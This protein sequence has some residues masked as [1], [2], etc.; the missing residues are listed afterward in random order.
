MSSRLRLLVTT[1]DLVGRGAERELVNLLR[2]IPRDRF[3]VHLCLWR[4]VFDYA[5]P[6]DVPVA[7]LDKRRWWHVFRARRRLARL[8]D[9]LQPDLVY[10]QL[11]YVSTVTGSALAAAR[12]PPAWI[13]RL[14]GN[15]RVEIRQPVLA[16]TR[17]SLRR[18]DAVVGCSRGAGR[19][20]VEHLRIPPQRVR[21]LPNVVDVDEVLRLAQAPSPVPK[22]PGVFVF[23]S[24][25]RLTP[26]KNHA[27]LLDAFARLN[28]PG[29]ELWILGEGPL[30]TSLQR[31]A[32]RLGI[33]ESVRW[34]G[35]QKNP[36]AVLRAADV[37]VLSSDYEGLP[38]ALIEA[39][40]CGLPAVSTDSPFGPAEL[41]DDGLGRLVPVGDAEALASAMRR[42]LDERARAA[43]TGRAARERIVDLLHPDRIVPQYL[44]LFEQCARSKERG[45]G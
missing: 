36:F 40:L 17:R 11:N 39:M 20:I 41:I 18:A 5:P 23:A 10:S 32:A 15:P 12:R 2:R 24:A 25:G 22:P 8:I 44:S 37:F 29:C 4:A 19:A 30:R 13:C 35:F 1:S 9:D 3:D 16:W 42:M 33:A 38:N 21:I 43:E 6:D 31:R 45:A 27:L 28:R 34:L 7:V 14:A 26:Q